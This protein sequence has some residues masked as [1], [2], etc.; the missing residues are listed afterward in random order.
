MRFMGLAFAVCWFATACAEDTPPWDQVRAELVAMGQRDQAVREGIT[1]A[2]L[3]DTVRLR[4]MLSVDSAHTRRLREIVD[5]YGWP[6]VSEV[7]EE[8]AHAAWLILQHTPDIEFQHRMLAVLE[9]AAERGEAS[10][11]ELALLTDRVLVRQGRPQR[12]GTQ[13]KFVDGQLVFHPIEAPEAVDERRAEVGLPP[14]EA[15][16][17]MS[18]EFF[19]AG[20]G[21]TPEVRRDSM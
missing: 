3:G 7:G 12:Y 8:G 2:S 13:F 9:A 19:A 15:Y 6:L 5:A 20:A 14:L 21:E 10:R 18:E 17:R 4:R 16:R 1:A 11:G